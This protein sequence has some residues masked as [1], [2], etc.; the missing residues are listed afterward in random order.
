M[1]ILVTGGA[2][3]IGSH[4]ARK[5]LKDYQLTIVDNLHAYY[6]PLQKQAHLNAIRKL[7][8]PFQFIETDLINESSCQKIFEANSFD[9]VIHLAALPG[10]PYS[11]QQPHQYIDLDIKAVVNILKH[12][13]E[14]NVKHVLFAS[15]SS[16]YG[17][18]A[19][20]A[21]TEGMANG[22]VVS[23]YAAAKYGAESFCHAYQSLYGFQLTIL[24]FFTVYGPWGRPDM[25]IPKF[26]KK[27]L[28]GE[29]IE[30]YGIQS[31][32]DYTYIDDIV[33]GIEKAL[34]YSKGNE[35]YNLGFGEPIYMETLLS[36]LKKRFPEMKT[37]QR[38]TRQGDVKMTWSNI[39][40]AKN[41]L[42][43]TPHVNIEEGL[44]RTISWA[45]QYFKN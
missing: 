36:H 38:Q 29:P 12:A 7:G 34:L 44:D 20:G 10:V 42:G 39:E 41:Q 33:N 26:I 35:T 17:D 3:F 30:I 32:R 45:K 15:S 40:K 13:G 1:N 2:G 27:L 16:V 6:D 24:R 31:A 37:I 23:P 22:Q 25:A 5:L 11:I 28:Y 43:Y 4:L 19:G 14:A 8:L 21:L 18:Q 9:A